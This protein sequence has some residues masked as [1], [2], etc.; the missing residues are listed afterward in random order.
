VGTII[1]EVPE[2]VSEEARKRATEAAVLALWEMGELSASRAAE[3]LDLSAHEFLD[4][5]SARGLPI[6]RHF[7]PE[8]VEA[9]RRKLNSGAPP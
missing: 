4:L 8:A 6:I 3:E 1:L 7:D 2:G 9:A 5:L